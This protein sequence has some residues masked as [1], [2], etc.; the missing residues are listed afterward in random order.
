MGLG[1]YRC[2][3]GLY[4]DIEPREFKSHGREME[5]YTETVVLVYHWGCISVALK[6]GY[7]NCM[8]PY[9]GIWRV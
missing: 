8:R 1:L 2:V 7:G 4:R 5:H 3:E 9:L 6:G